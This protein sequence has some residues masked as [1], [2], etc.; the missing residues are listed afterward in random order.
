MKRWLAVGF[1]LCLVSIL[2][3]FA[4]FVIWNRLTSTSQADVEKLIRNNIPVGSTASAAILFLDSKDI[5]HGDVERAAPSSTLIDAGVPPEMKVI[6][7]IF[8]NTSHGFFYTVHIEF[9]LILDRD[10]RIVSYYF[11]EVY[12]GL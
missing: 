9:W 11:N 12:D 1:V 8:R 5:S 10:E 2:A 6:N 4:S 7:G 3:L